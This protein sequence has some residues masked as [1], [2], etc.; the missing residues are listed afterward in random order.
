[1]MPKIKFLMNFLIA[2]NDVLFEKDN[3]KNNSMEFEFSDNSKN[4]SKTSYSSESVEFSGN[5]VTKENISME[6]EFP[7]ENQ[8]SY[9]TTNKT[10][11]NLLTSD[12]EILLA[13][14]KGKNTTMELEFPVESEN[15]S[16]NQN[17]TRNSTYHSDKDVS[18]LTSDLIIDPKSVSGSFETTLD[19]N[20]SYS[21]KDLFNV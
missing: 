12:E 3:D 17:I 14:E 1:M 21:G 2:E 11:N 8:T 7:G 15:V 4:N 16:E 13:E 9:T 10:S 18:I 6:V 19:S 5:K 20:E